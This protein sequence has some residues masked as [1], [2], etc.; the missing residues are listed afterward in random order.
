VD[1]LAAMLRGKKADANTRI[2][3]QAMLPERVRKP[4]AKSPQDKGTAEF[5]SPDRT[6]NSPRKT[7]R[8]ASTEAG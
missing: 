7:R 5:D 3:A 8:A 4:S 2:E 6:T 1:E